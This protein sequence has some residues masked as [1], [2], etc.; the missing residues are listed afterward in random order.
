MR[1]RHSV[2][3]IAVI[4]FLVT[5]LEIVVRLGTLRVGKSIFKKI[6]KKECV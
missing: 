3:F 4:Q 6:E 2:V 1:A 5:V